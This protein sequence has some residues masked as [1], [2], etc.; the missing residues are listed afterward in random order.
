MK[1]YALIVAGGQGNRMG[2]RIPKQ[3]LEIAG[4][5]VLMHSMGVFFHYDPLMELIVVLPEEQIPYWESLCKTYTHTPVH[6][7]CPGGETR[8]HSV[9]NGLSRISDEGIVFIHD[10][11]RP[12]VSRDTLDRCYQSAVNNGNAVPVWPV[13]ESLRIVKKR[14]TRAVDRSEYL[15]VQT[16][17]T[18]RISEIKDAYQQEYHPLFTDDASVLEATGKTIFLVSGNPEN[19]KITYPEDLKI[20]SHLMKPSP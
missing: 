10:G 20:I 4:K 16:P 8:F 12:L 14:E 13:N 18:F 17:Q 2:G 3:F 15:T 7:V 5:T 6:A 9:K 19:I 1:K 11:V